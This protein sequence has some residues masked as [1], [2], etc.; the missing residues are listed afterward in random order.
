MPAFSSL[1]L[2]GQLRQFQGNGSPDE[3]G[4]PL[5]ILVSNYPFADNYLM[6]GRS[7]QQVLEAILELMDLHEKYGMPLKP[8]VHNLEGVSDILGNPEDTKSNALGLTWDIQTDTLHPIFHYHL[9][10]M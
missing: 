8:P 2:L 10:G 3:E 7:K 1:G 6:S 5:A 4:S 9:K